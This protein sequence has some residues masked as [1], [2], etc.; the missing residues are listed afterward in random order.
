MLFVFLYGVFVRILASDTSVNLFVIIVAKSSLLKQLHREF[1]ILLMGR[2]DCLLHFRRLSSRD[3]RRLEE[4]YK[5]RVSRFVKEFDDFS[6]YIIKKS[7][8]QSKRHIL[9]IFGEKVREFKPDKIFLPTDFDNLIKN[10]NKD[11]IRIIRMKPIIDDASYPV[12]VSDM[13]INLYRR[14]RN[15]TYF[16]RANIYVI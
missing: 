5:E 12:Q 6:I 13:L 7:F 11:F 3:K 1:C 16:S 8:K 15:P 4:Y 2:G 10:F 9:N 14:I